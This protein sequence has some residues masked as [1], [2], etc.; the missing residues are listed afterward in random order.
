MKID[1]LTRIVPAGE[2][3]EDFTVEIDQERGSIT[4]RGGPDLVD[5]SAEMFSSFD[6]EDEYIIEQNVDDLAAKATLSIP[7]QGSLLG[8]MAELLQVVIDLY[9]DAI[10]SEDWQDEANRNYYRSLGV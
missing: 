4:I 2:G 5:V 3:F 7:L 9:A 8:A 6:L 10:D 1:N